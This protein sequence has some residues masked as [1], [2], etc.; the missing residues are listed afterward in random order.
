MNAPLDVLVLGC[1]AIGVTTAVVLQ[2]AGHRVRIWARD[3]PPN[4]TSSVAAAFWY[5]YRVH[6]ALRVVAWARQSFDDFAA[7]ATSAPDAGVVRR[8]ALELLAR[9]GAPSWAAALP[10]FRPARPEELPP[11]HR[12]GVVFDSFVVE[13][14]RY[15]PWL[16]RRFLAAGGVI[17]RRV[18]ERPDEALAA[19]DAV[20][21]CAGLGARGLAPD[22]AVYPVRGQL[23]RVDN[24]GLD[25]VIVDEESGPI[26]YIVPRQED[27]I[28]GGTSDEGATDLTPDPGCGAAILERC[29]ALEPRLRGVRVLGDL[30]GLRPCRPE[31]RLERDLAAPRPL[32]HNY[33][34]GGAGIT[35]S[36]GCAREAAALLLA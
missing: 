34:H 25:R 16:R 27:V 30:V 3:E 33:G 35:L 24:P 9:P 18:L 6:P 14:P 19:A 28:L 23:L 2:E 1:G 11:G 10:S 13:T 8:P 29:V 22:P 26:T 12:A 7:L 15:L 17:E 5:P 20:V 36:W 32:V 21:H 31:V 4:T